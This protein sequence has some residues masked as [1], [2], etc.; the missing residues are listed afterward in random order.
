MVIHGRNFNTFII[1]KHFVSYCALIISSIHR[2]ILCL[3]YTFLI[4]IIHRCRKRERARAVV[5]C[6]VE[7][8]ALCAYHRNPLHIVVVD[9]FGKCLAEKHR[10]I[11]HT[12]QKGAQR[13]PARDTTSGQLQSGPVCSFA[14]ERGWVAKQQQQRKGMEAPHLPRARAAASSSGTAT[15]ACCIDPTIHPSTS[16]ILPIRAKSDSGVSTKTQ[17]R[18]RHAR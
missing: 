13:G 3:Q 10:L 14:V 5:L 8:F 2:V 17:Q 11:P 16:P 15:P 7:G 12:P 18:R 4:P 1:L 6:C 9:V